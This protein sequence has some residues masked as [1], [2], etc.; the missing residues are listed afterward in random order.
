MVYLYDA[1]EKA[2]TTISGICG[3]EDRRYKQYWDIID[4]SF[5]GSPYSSC[6]LQHV[7]RVLVL[8][9]DTQIEAF[10]E[11][12]EF[13]DG[14]GV[15]RTEIAIPIWTKLQLDESLDNQEMIED[16]DI[17]VL[18]VQDINGLSKP[19]EILAS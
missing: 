12:D 7:I 6:A 3:N 9:M 1:L 8:D 18:D 5:Q 17:S 15:L 13:M 16:D 14:V 10:A 11:V 4:K 2:K 19:N